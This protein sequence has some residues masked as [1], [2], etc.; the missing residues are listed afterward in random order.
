MVTKIGQRKFLLKA[1]YTDEQLDRMSPSHAHN[2]IRERE[3]ISRLK[4]ETSLRENS[5]NN[6][7]PDEIEI[8]G[9][10]YKRI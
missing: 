3:R 10:R 7:L 2:I 8:N 4:R 5:I 1:G 9:I 6:E